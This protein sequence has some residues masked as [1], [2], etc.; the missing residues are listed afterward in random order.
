MRVVVE[1]W[2]VVGAVR[3]AIDRWVV[4]ELVPVAGVARLADVVPESMWE[5][6]VDRSDR[7]CCK[8]YNKTSALAKPFNNT[9]DLGHTCWYH[10]GVLKC[11]CLG[12]V[13]STREAGQDR[14]FTRV[15]VDTLFDVRAGTVWWHKIFFFIFY[16]FFLWK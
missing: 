6:C 12:F 2:L 13:P 10:I 11:V 7:S 8:R 14:S 9:D 16:I 15:A 4:K 3:E 1:G 5:K